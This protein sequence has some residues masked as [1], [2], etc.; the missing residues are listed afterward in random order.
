MTR[1]MNLHTILQVILELSVKSPS[2]SCPKG[3]LA[4]Y[5]LF[6]GYWQSDEIWV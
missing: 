1:V 4:H 3:A 5:P 6:Q 2:V